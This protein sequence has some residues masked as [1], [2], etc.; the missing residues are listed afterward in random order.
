MYVGG[1]VGGIVTSVC[2]GRVGGIVQIVFRGELV[3]L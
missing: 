2:G 3:E 1:R